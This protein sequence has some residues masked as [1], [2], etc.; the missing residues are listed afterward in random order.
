MGNNTSLESGVK[1]SPSTKVTESLIVILFVGDK[2]LSGKRLRREAR[3]RMDHGDAQEREQ[4]VVSV[5]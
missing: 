3:G 5:D 4:D 1:E 2:G